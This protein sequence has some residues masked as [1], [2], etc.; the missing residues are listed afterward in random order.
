MTDPLHLTKYINKNIIISKE[1]EC[2][3]EH[4]QICFQE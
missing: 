2:T 3:L 4:F 1:L